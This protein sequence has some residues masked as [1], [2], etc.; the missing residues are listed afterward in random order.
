MTPQN[1]LIITDGKAGDEGPSRALG[2]A[3]KGALHVVTVRPRL[4]WVGLMPWGPPDPFDWKRLDLI[5]LVRAHEIDLVIATGRRA[6][7]YVRSLKARLPG[8]FCVFLKDPRVSPT[9]ADVIWV[10]SHDRL[11]GPNVVTTVTGPH[12]FRPRALQ[13]R[14]A[15][16]AASYSHFKPLKVAVLVG[17]DSRHMRFTPSCQRRFR[18]KLQGL[19][20]KDHSLLITTSRRTPTALTTQLAEQF[21]A[22]APHLLWQGEGP[23]PL[24]DFLAL[25]DA[26]VVTADS[27]NM[28]GEAAAT[29]KPI[30]V[31]RPAGSSKKLDQQYQSLAD[32]GAVHAWTDKNAD[33]LLGSSYEPID[34]MPQIVDFISQA[35]MLKQ[36]R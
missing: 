31:F 29:G 19:V 11:R 18:A 27:A 25:A 8:L 26:V 33:N 35:S 23:N 21:G 3:L 1:I 17:G 16:I 30:L 34:A 13:A 32:L 24:F 7:P 20:D 4:P 9:L 6:V 36:V 15:E 28:M 10:P 2:D 22:S 5:G 14:R 12:R